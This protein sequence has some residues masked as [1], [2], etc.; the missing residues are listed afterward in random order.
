[1][2]EMSH[3]VL[4]GYAIFAGNEMHSWERFEVPTFYIRSTTRVKYGIWHA[5]MNVICM[6]VCETLIKKK[7]LCEVFVGLCH[8]NKRV[9]SEF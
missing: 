4:N 5:Y 8:E 7:R 2:Y 1:M 9:H 6:T 3:S